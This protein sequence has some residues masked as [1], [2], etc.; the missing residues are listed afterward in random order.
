MTSPAFIVIM[1]SAGIIVSCII[2]SYFDLRYTIIPNK[3]IIGI[4]ISLFI[5]QLVSGLFFNVWPWESPRTWKLYIVNI[6]L[7]II[8]AFLLH[9]YDIWAPGDAKFFIV[10]SLFFPHELYTSSHNALFPSLQIIVWS[11][12]LGYLYLVLNLLITKSKRTRIREMQEPARNSFLSASFWRNYLISIAISF[13]LTHFVFLFAYDFYLSNRI[14]C[15]LTISLI[16]RFMSS[17]PLLIRIMLA[18]VL[19]ITFLILGKDQWALQGFSGRLFASVALIMFIY[20]L[21]TKLMN[22]NY[23]AVPPEELQPGMILSMMTIINVSSTSSLSLPVQTPESRRSKLN[24]QQVSALQRWAIKND[25]QLIILRTIPFVPFISA[26]VLSEI[27]LGYL[28]RI[29]I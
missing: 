22:N 27:V 2:A 7:T 26:G 5:I 21:N 9:Y 18:G 16:L 1:A 24:Q 17:K 13:F 10:I 29:G 6:I 28:I 23:E 4:A 12:S 11:F 3:L 15:I 19:L 8:T 25:Q 20:S 14:V